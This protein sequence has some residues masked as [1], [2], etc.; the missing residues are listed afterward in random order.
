ME[1]YMSLKQ[2]KCNINIYLK[3]ICY[4]ISQS[5][6][7]IDFEYC[8]QQL[9]KFRTDITTKAWT[10]IHLD[11]EMQDRWDKLVERKNDL[12]QTSREKSFKIFELQEKIKSCEEIITKNNLSTNDKK[13]QTEDGIEKEEKSSFCDIVIYNQKND[14]KK[15]DIPHHIKNKI[16]KK[17]NDGNKKSIEIKLQLSLNDTATTTNVQCY[18]PE[19]KKRKK[20]QEN[21]TRRNKRRRIEKIYID[22]HQKEYKEKTNFISEN[23]NNIHNI[24]DD[25]THSIIVTSTTAANNDTPPKSFSARSLTRTEW[26]LYRD[27]FQTFIKSYTQV[28]FKIEEDKKNNKNNEKLQ[29][30]THISDIA[31]DF[32]E[33]NTLG[34][35]L[36]NGTIGCLLR[37]F[38]Q[39]KTGEYQWLQSIQNTW[40]I[41]KKVDIG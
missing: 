13:C 9:D 14:E 1:K 3:N 21:L 32:H 6:G 24:N 38:K 40:N 29:K 12:I 4:L 7:E 10:E 36:N 25:D 37:G 34:G 20:S 2:Y 22:N 27:S 5:N 17:D 28:P 39:K 19:T 11:H 18:L 31:K 16:W 8:H 26:N 30:W 15:E 35:N 41:T 23:E 33:W